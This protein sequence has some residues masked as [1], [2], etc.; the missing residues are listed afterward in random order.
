MEDERWWCGLIG[1]SL[2]KKAIIKRA[3]TFWSWLG[4]SRWD[5]ARRNSSCWPV[6]RFWCEI[7][8][9]DDAYCLAGGYLNFASLRVSLFYLLVA[10]LAWVSVEFRLVAACLLKMENVGIHHEAGAF[11]GSITLL[12][13]WLAGM[14]SLS[15]G[16][17]AE[18]T[19]LRTFLVGLIV[20]K[21][22]NV[23]INNGKL[24]RLRWQ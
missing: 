16:E 7:W 12:P 6:W 10:H 14:F 23:W 11:R 13:S 15:I 21:S 22:V 19:I 1:V 2:I 8:P 17:P 18:I 5:F 4:L 9:E 20:C 3:T 24:L